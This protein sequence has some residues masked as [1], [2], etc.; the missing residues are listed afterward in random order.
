MVFLSLTVEHYFMFL[1]IIIGAMFS[2]FGVLLK[3]NLSRSKQIKLE[4]LKLY[5]NKKRKAY[6]KLYEFTAR[7]FF[8]NFPPDDSRKDF[9][10][11]MQ[12]YFKNVKPNYLFFDKATKKELQKLESQYYSLIT[13][14]FI[15]IVPFEEFFRNHLFKIFNN[16]NNHIESIFEKWDKF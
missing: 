14:E 11:I 16:I 15:S 10:G 3:E 1:G 2:L 7:S 13:P 8:N 9:L 6:V 5:D 12:D 4:K